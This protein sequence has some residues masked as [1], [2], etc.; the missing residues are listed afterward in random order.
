MRVRHGGGSPS[1]VLA[2][3]SRLL[4]AHQLVGPLRE[5]VDDLGRL[6][7]SR[8]GATLIRALALGLEFGQLMQQRII[9][10]ALLLDVT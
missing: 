10:R 9:L 6:A 1:L 4:W 3:S 8:D 2:C 5:A 7:P